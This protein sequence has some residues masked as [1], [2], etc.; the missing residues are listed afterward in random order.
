MTTTNEPKRVIYYGRECWLCIT[1]SGN[2]YYAYTDEPPSAEDLVRADEDIS[3]AASVPVWD[4]DYDDSDS[5]GYGWENKALR[6]IP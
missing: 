4:Y 6:G 2:E 5:D 3:Y 1:P